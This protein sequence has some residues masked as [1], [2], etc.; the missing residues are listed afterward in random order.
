[1]IYQGAVLQEAIIEADSIMEAWNI[2]HPAKSD[3]LLMSGQGKPSAWVELS[4][5]LSVGEEE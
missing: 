4:P 5:I 2:A 3:P 1:M